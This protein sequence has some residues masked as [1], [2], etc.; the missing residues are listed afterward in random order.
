M[1]PMESALCTVIGHLPSS[2]V[3][4]QFICESDSN[5]EAICSG[6]ESTSTILNGNAL[7]T[8]IPG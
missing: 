7:G 6:L 4:F 3:A 8:C 1:L 2:W 5:S